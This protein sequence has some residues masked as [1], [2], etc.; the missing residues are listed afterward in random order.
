MA[1][2]TPD[3]VIDPALQEVPDNVD[4]VVVCNGQPSS[5]ADATTDSGSG[6]N[7][8][9]EATVG[10]AD[11]TGPADGDTSGRK[12]TFD[13]ATG[14]DVDVSATA[15]HVAFV[16]D[17]NSTLLLVTTISNSQSVTAGN[18]A[19]VGSFDREIQDPS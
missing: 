2:L 19:D 16:D 14:I 1:K 5:Y 9:G 3:N 6:G 10:P 17:D 12:I 4:Q 15:D 11:F 18:T 8:L 13:G 7:A